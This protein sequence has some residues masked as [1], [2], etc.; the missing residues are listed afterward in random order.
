MAWVSDSKKTVSL[1]QSPSLSLNNLTSN[2]S[3]FA[4]V[5]KGD[6]I[7]CG[8]NGMPRQTLVND[9]GV[10][11]M[12]VLLCSGEDFD[13]LVVALN[14]G[15]Q[16]WSSDG[17]RLIYFFDAKIAPGSSSLIDSGHF[18]QGI[19]MVP[20]GRNFIVGCSDGD[21]FAF[22]AKT[23]PHGEAC[24][25]SATLRGH[26]QPITCAGADSDVCVSGDAGGTII[27]WSI[28][29]HLERE[30]TF[31]GDGYPATAL[32]ARDG[33]VVA[34]YST[35]HVRVFDR[36]NKALAIEIAAHSRSINAMDLHPSSMLLATVGEDF[37]M[38]VWELPECRQGGPSGQV[39]LL[40][41]SRVDNRLLTGVRFLVDG[42]H[43]II[44]LAYDCDHLQM[45]H[46]LERITPSP[47]CCTSPAAGAAAAQ[48]Y[49]SSS[50]NS[51]DGGFMIASASSGLRWHVVDTVRNC[52]Y[53]EVLR[54]VEVM[55]GGCFAIKQ[56]SLERIH[57]MDARNSSEDPLKEV[58]ALQ[59][60]KAH[61]PHPNVIDI[62]EALHDNEYIYVVL[63]FCTEGELFSVVSTNHR[64]S[65][66]TARPIFRGL[67]AGMDFLHNLQICH[68]D[69]SLENI[70]LADGGVVKIIDFG[71][72]L[73]LQQPPG[74]R[75]GGAAA[76]GGG[77]D[78][79]GGAGRRGARSMSPTGPFGKRHY[80]PPEVAMNEQEYDGFSVDVWA[81]GVIMFITLAGIPPFHI[82]I[83]TQD[84]RCQFVA[85]ERRLLELVRG[86]D[87]N[88]S[89]EVVSLIQ[90]CL[91]FNPNERS[92]GGACEG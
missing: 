21:V 26:E 70:L 28:A 23:G 35:G 63:P 67:L 84:D 24:E 64:L 22:L 69:M 14:T 83:P 80:M 90:S 15:V 73:K 92:S 48:E 8:L 89:T 59:F 54:A 13:F 62:V 3:T 5:H 10:R 57:G 18:T 37:F 56:M 74:P 58:A 66:D 43:R 55:H 11:A 1:K 60:L 38:N 88:L 75:G 20:R 6:V 29:K 50:N 53:G 25:L 85:V 17:K 42:S 31:D 4:Y 72:A 65:E 61:G 68:R 47:Y 19:G 78:V 87:L 52:L 12:E 32:C 51:G 2:V 45:W 79:S 33:T 49:S 81:C 76:F 27:A 91:I 71:M 82:P 34:S 41:T 39:G 44:A 86:W 30:C 16:I 46:K 40:A 9:G 77:G 36:N 7:I